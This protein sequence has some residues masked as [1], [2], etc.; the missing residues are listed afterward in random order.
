V[1]GDASSTGSVAC[2]GSWAG[3][4]GRADGQARTRAGALACLAACLRPCV[5]VCVCWGGG[6]GGCEGA[7]Q[8][9]G[10]RQPPAT[11]LSP[12]FGLCGLQPCTKLTATWTDS[13]DGGRQVGGKYT[14]N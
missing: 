7:F 4:E 5:C 13:L 1:G 6:G 9:T 2:V 11:V 8:A 3:G 14:P 10:A 12:N